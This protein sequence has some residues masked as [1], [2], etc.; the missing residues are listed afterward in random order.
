MA[1]NKEIKTNAMR[2][3]EKEKIS[4][5]CH[6]YECDEFTD[7]IQIADMLSLPHEKVYKTLVTIGNSKNY[8]VF[9]VPVARELDLK[10]AAKAVG[11][12]SVSM[13][14]VKDINQVTGY[15]R[16]GCTAVGMKKQYV[17][18]LDESARSKDKIYVSG[19]RIGSQIELKPDDLLKACRGEYADVVVRAGNEI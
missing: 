9:V 7:G 17:T 8:F 5:I 19:G 1:K 12:K 18:R 6:T 14:H 15:I 13:I 11:E 3:L 16:G 10:K 2:I 4:F